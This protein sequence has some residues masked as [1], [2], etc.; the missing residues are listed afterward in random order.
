MSDSVDG[1]RKAVEAPSQLG[2][3]SPELSRNESRRDCP[4]TNPSKLPKNYINRQI[5]LNSKVDYLS[6]LCVSSC[7]CSI[8]FK[9]L[10]VFATLDAFT[11]QKTA[12]IET[13][14]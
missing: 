3:L 12:D 7:F 8:F 2:L 5:R 14:T 6:A 10:S 9:L 13:Y 1:C 4:T 11:P